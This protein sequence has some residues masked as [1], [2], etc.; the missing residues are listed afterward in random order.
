[1]DRK[2]SYGTIATASIL[3]GDPASET[4]HL[5]TQTDQNQTIQL[6]D[7]QIKDFDLSHNAESALTLFTILGSAVALK[8][9]S[10]EV[11]EIRSY[12]SSGLI[13]A[14]MLLNSETAEASE[15]RPNTNERLPETIVIVTLI[16]MVGAAAAKAL[17]NKANG[18]N[19]T[20]IPITPKTGQDLIEVPRPLN[21]VERKRLNSDFIRAKSELAEMK[22]PNKK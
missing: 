11:S 5:Q 6:D 1:M 3:I 19:K 2:T 9:L 8:A 12:L 13:A 17:E 21:D 20:E 14:I 22:G 18:T 10:K 7:M 16:V 4:E 15:P